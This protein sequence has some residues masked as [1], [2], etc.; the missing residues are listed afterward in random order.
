MPSLDAINALVKSPIDWK[1]YCDEQASEK[2]DLKLLKVDCHLLECR[3]FHLCDLSGADLSSKK[4]DFSI[5]KRSELEKVNFIQ[6]S[7]FD[8]RFESTKIKQCEFDTAHFKRCIF[9]D[10]EIYD[11]NVSDVIFENI[12]FQGCTFF[13]VDFGK[14]VLDSVKF[15]N[16][17]LTNVLF[18]TIRRTAVLFEYCELTNYNCKSDAALEPHFVHCGLTEIKI[19]APQV[20]GG[21][22]RAS[23]L[24]NLIISS[25]NVE[26]IDFC[27]CRLVDIDI[28]TIG[29]MTAHFLNTAFIKCKWPE[30]AGRT[31]FFGKYQPAAYLIAHPVQDVK[32]ISPKLRREIADAQF[33]VDLHN[34]HHGFFGKFFLALWGFSSGF[35]QSILRL[36]LFSIFTLIL[37]AGAICSIRFKSEDDLSLESIKV[38]PKLFHSSLTD[39]MTSF[40]SLAQTGAN[41]PSEEIVLNSVKVLSYIILGIW[42][43]VC[44]AKLVKLSSD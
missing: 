20:V 21:T 14:V 2:I 36:F 6:S 18:K 3:S 8:V 13:G 40:F 42:A 22:F 31:T 17:S 35:G 25:K 15:K 33:L 37:H 30:Q 9:I 5:F 19:S 41:T 39:V 7:F 27:D 1:Q 23:Y 10:C 38:I 34:C 24:K 26:S 43:S 16:C 11:L 12:E 32:G 28:K 44:A 4:L 29:P